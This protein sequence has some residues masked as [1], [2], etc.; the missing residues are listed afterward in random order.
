MAFEN[1]RLEVLK[2][3]ETKQVTPEEGARLLAALGD[4][5]RRTEPARASVVSSATSGRWF[6]LQVQSPGSENVSL[7]LPL[8]V[9]PTI[10][11]V[12]ERWVPEQ[13]REVLGAVS[14]ALS[15]DIRGEILQVDEPGGQRVRIWIE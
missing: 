9:V 15:S 11:R 13:H 4:E 2:M 12:A 7:T 6:R 10:L 14:D 3:I 8:A 1:E 5:R